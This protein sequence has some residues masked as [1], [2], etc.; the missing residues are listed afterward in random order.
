MSD[1]RLTFDD[2]PA[3]DTGALLGVL[4]HHGVRATFFLVGER[5]S[6]R[7]D[8]VARMAAEGHVLGNH[9]WDHPDLR[10]LSLESVREQLERTSD[11]I[12]LA[13]GVRPEV[14]RPP[15][16]YTSPAIEETALSVGMSTQLW[17]VDTADYADPGVQEVERAIAS[18][19]AGS[20]VLLHDG[21][22]ERASTV[23]AVDRVLRS[24]PAAGPVDQ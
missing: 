5:V 21:P 7:R 2:G 17:D 8:L 14:F 1:R 10:T 23:E 13:A 11:A 22:G 9:S 19:P 4:A 16:G 20:V 12:E 15:F 6:A 3:E 18:A 24:Q